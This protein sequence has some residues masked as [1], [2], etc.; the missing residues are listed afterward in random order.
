M[1]PTKV[2]AVS[3]WPA[4][5]N[6]TELQRFIGFANFYRRFIDQFSRVARPLHDLTKK[7][8]KFD[9]PPACQSAFDKLKVAFTS[10]PILKI[11]DPYRP[12]ILECDCSDFALGAV[13]SQVC[14]KDNLLHPV[15][16][17]SRSL[18]K[19]ERDYA[20]FDKELLAI[21]ASFKEW[22][23]YL[24]GNPHR[25]HAIVYTDH[26]NLENF[27][28]TKELTRRQARWAEILGCFDFD[29]VFLPGREAAHPDALSCQPDLAPDK[30]DKLSFGQ[31]LRPDNIRPDTFTAIAEF[32]ACFV[33]ESVDLENADFWFD[34]DVLG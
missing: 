23:H 28:T 19:A 26:R 5:R 17:L 18:I 33:N 21:V 1:D 3:D 13:L 31:I 32:E 29:I 24:E 16:Y 25:L 10:A 12:F 2:K 4:P 20:I 34:V 15:A 7:D 14:P 11:A 27:M 8:T 22:R 6:V 30:A 9:W